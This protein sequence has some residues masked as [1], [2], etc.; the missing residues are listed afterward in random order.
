MGSKS[1]MHWRQVDPEQNVAK[2]EGSFRSHHH[3]R[4]AYYLSMWYVLQILFWNQRAFNND[5][6]IT[7]SVIT[8]KSYRI[9][10]VTT[11]HLL[12]STK[13]SLQ[14]V[15]GN[16]TKTMPTCNLF[17]MPVGTR[18]EI[19]FLKFTWYM[20]VSR[21]KNCTESLTTVFGQDVVW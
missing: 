18:H 7:R 11:A 19:N 9:S 16:N 21:F 4:L 5:R 3:A 20:S 1:K 2:H 14:K 13:S 12:K 8:T 10:N 15:G 6:L 17:G